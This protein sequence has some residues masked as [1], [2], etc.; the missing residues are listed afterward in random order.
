MA[1]DAMNKTF[2]RLAA[3][4]LALAGCQSQTAEPP[5]AGARLGGPFSLTDQ[6]GHRVTDTQFAGRYRLVY[7]GYTFCPDACP[8]DMQ[9]LMSGLKLFEQRDAA[10]AAKVQPIFITIDPQRDTPPVLKQWVSAFHPR[11]IGLVGT[12]AETAAVAKEYAVIYQKV[13]TPGSTSYL[14]DHT[15]TAVLFGPK[16]EPIALIPQDQTAEVAAAELAKWVQ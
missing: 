13:E 3:S 7:F 10:A 8:A 5:L 16:G 4:L 12:P 15:R 6:N 14:M 9:I 2:T 11:L 1:G